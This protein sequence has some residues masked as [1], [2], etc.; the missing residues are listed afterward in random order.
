MGLLFAVAFACEF[1]DSSLGMGYGTTLTPL[2]MLLG[3]GPLRVVPVV[4]LSEF[5]TGLTAGGFHQS[6]GNANFRRG[7]RDRGVVAVLSLAGV[8]GAIV[9]VFVAVSIS[10]VALKLY[11]AVMI[12][13]M[14]ILILWRRN[15]RSSFS[16]SKIAGL[17]LISAFNKGMS[18]GGYGPIVTGGQILSGCEGRT[19]V[20]CTSIA[21]ALICLVGVIS[22]VFVK[23]WPDPVLALPIIVG[24]TISAPCAALTTKVLDRKTRLEVLIGIVVLVLGAVTLWKAL[25]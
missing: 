21:E 20:G 12:L 2:L 5:I 19:A 13:A 16:W 3:F 9:A 17:G 11:I 6:L 14:G 8:V 18:G 4:L 25:A 24:A 23:G 22:Y 15:H 7:S 10:K 1:V